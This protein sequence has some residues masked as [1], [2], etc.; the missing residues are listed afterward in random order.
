MNELS[1]EDSICPGIYQNAQVGAVYLSVEGSSSKRNRVYSLVRAPDLGFESLLTVADVARM[2]Q[3]PVS[4][5]Y[6]HTRPGCRDPLPCL[7]LGKY[8]RFQA[9]RLQSYIEELRSRNG[10]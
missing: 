4:W 1:V 8:V 10:Q 7:R 9:A 2:L 3:V 5:V 6:E